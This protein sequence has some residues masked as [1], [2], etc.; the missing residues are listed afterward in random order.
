MRNSLI[1]TE[2]ATSPDG[3]KIAYDVNGSG[4]ALILLHGAGKDRSGWHEIGY[5]DRLKDHFKVIAVDMRG[6][7]ESDRRTK[8]DD[9]AI[10]KLFADVHSIADACAV[11]RFAI[12]GF[13]LGGNIARYLGAWSARVRCIVVGGVAFGAAISNAQW[14]RDLQ[15]RWS[16][17]LAEYVR[18]GDVPPLPDD[19]RDLLVSGR[20][21]GSLA[22]FG[23]M[24]TWPPIEPADMRC[25]ALVVVGSRNELTGQRLAA[26]QSALADAGIHVERFEGLDHAGE[27]TQIDRVLPAVYKFLQNHSKA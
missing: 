6:A 11:D 24:L 14:V 21:A 19:E 5:V 20:V 22:L 8:T 4:P 18:S 10:E 12:W 27:F 2:F 25:P 1:V 3:A 13:S 9:Y 17:I 26:Q 7:G 23:A 15:A 16:P